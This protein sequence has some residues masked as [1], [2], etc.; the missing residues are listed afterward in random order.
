MSNNQN[1]IQYKIL[2]I[3]NTNVGKTSV[4]KKMITGDFS[5]KNISTIGMDQKTIYTE[6]ELEKNEDKKQ[7]EK[8]SFEVTILDTAGQEKFRA[9]TN[10][11]FKGADGILI[12]YD[13]TN[14]Q[15]FEQVKLWIESLEEALGNH[16][17]GKYLIILIGNKIDLVEKGQE[18]EVEEYEAKEKCEDSDF[19]WG[20]EIS[21][22]TFTKEQ[23]KEKMDEFIGQMF[24]KLGKK[25][26][27]KQI[28]KK[29]DMHRKKKKQKFC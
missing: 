9:I 1:K 22:K 14:R 15:S 7:K 28:T 19:Y 20:G 23:L 13:V 16:K 29:I 11:F 3:G 25:L 5:D 21:A 24:K 18:K 17:T 26:Q 4:L 8:Y 6:L 12:L 2:L 27:G 10:S